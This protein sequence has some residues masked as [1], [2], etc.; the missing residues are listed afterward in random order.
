MRAAEVTERQ[1]FYPQ[2]DN[3]QEELFRGHISG[4]LQATNRQ[5][6]KKEAI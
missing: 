5:S 1:A 4:R 6:I 2:P 3:R